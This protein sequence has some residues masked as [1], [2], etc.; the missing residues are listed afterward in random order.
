MSALALSSQWAKEFKPLVMPWVLSISGAVV[1]T[2]LALS[3]QTDQ[4]AG[5]VAD[6]GL[7]AFIG[8]L[9]LQA[10][11][12]FGSEFQNR[13]LPLLLTQPWSRSRV[14]NRK[15]AVLAA[16]MLT[17]I[18]IAILIVSLLSLTQYSPIAGGTLGHE[19]VG[20]IFARDQIV[21]SA[22]FL[23]ATA[24]SCCFW[25]LIA[26]S[27]IGGLVLTATAEFLAGLIV[28]LVV[29][30]V[31]GREDPFENPHTPLI[32]LVAGVVYC[33]IFLELGRR[34]FLALQLRDAH[35]GEY[36]LSSR[37]LLQGRWAPS[38]LTC[39]PTERVLNLVRKEIGL[40]RPLFQIAKLFVVCWLAIFGLELI[41]PRHEYIKLFTVLASIY[42]AL[43]GLLAG[44]VPL[45]E[46]KSLGLV[47]PQR[48]LPAS[49]IL[50]WFVKFVVGLGC[51]LILG[52]G[53]A[54][55]LA[56]ATSGFINLE[57]INPT[58]SSWLAIAVVSSA[59]FLLGFW[60]VHHTGNTIR[61]AL[62]AV[63]GSACVVGCVALGIWLSL[64]VWGLQTDLVITLMCHFHLPPDLVVQRC[65]SVIMWSDYGIAAL[66]I[67]VM[68]AQSLNRFRSLQESTA[69][70]VK[71][72]ALLASIICLGAFWTMDL[73]KSAGV[74]PNS[75]PVDELRRAIN[76]IAKQDPQPNRRTE[77]LIT[78]EDL[79]TR[80]SDETKTWLKGATIS[81][82]MQQ[83]NQFH[84]TFKK[85]F[86]QTDYWVT[87]E[88]SNGKEFGFSGGWGTDPFRRRYGF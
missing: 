88:F 22:I 68:L 16:S 8:G 67:L 15:M 59:F 5:F 71:N 61:A 30:R 52:Q 64:E 40:Q 26:E 55:A 73:S 86:L 54:W 21:M 72:A 6:L 20:P 78:A 10:A 82:R 13:T 12:A 24:C 49:P 83:S 33:A 75:F 2:L 36:G 69:R 70:L 4:F 35:V 51:V 19:A 50:Q 39:R 62:H 60:S 27:T 65:S 58:E 25:T 76:T 45:G 42:V 28:M 74:L 44:C 31:T 57:D 63:I 32:I 84:P 38:W 29:S 18:L 81:Y 46:E 37:G 11:L 3:G 34:K 53:L 85:G 17:A 56:C 66:V 79:E 87:V 47:G 1:V 48:T 23:L 9:A 80:I 14:W 77:R 7:Y 43:C 41:Q